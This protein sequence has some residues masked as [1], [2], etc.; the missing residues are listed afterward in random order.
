[1]H[2]KY[3][4]FKPQEMDR[5]FIL[6]VALASVKM[7]FFVVLLLG[8]SFM[9]L[10][11]GVGKAWVDTSPALDLEVLHSQSQTSFIYDK[12]N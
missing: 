8:F 9:G 4:I 1:M 12:Y 11:V 3:A 7:M 10:G 6:S 2:L 5:N